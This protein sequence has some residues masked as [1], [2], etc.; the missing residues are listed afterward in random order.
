MTTLYQQIKT[1]QLEARKAKITLTSSLLTTLLG[2]IQSSTIGTTASS[3]GDFNPSDSEVLK[4]INKFIKNAKETLKLK[5]DNVT[6]S[7]E[8]KLLE[9]YLPKQLTDDE[10]KQII[11]DIVSKFHENVQ[12]NGRI[13]LVMKELKVNY[14]NRYDASKVKDIILDI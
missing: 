13:G 10:L 1:E 9:N 14:E 12:P 8:L 3:S 11:S 5:P 7:L 6:V 2:E 4:V